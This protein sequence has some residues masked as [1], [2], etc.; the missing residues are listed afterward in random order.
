MVDMYAIPSVAVIRKV[1]FGAPFFAFRVFAV[2]SLIEFVGDG[3]LFL[4]VVIVSCFAFDGNFLC[5]K[6]GGRWLI[7]L[8]QTGSIA[9]GVHKLNFGSGVDK[10]A[11]AWSGEDR[12]IVVQRGKVV[13]DDRVIAC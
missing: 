7:A 10:R 11:T 1:I 6:A 4:L 2:K 5:P 12:S 8:T 9:R 13:G 3:F